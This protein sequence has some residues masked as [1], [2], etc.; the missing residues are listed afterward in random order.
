[1]GEKPVG[2]LILKTA[3]YIFWLISAFP[4]LLWDGMF[5]LLRS[6]ILISVSVWVCGLAS[7]QPLELLV[8]KAIGTSE[9]P[10][11]VGESLRRV[12]ECVASGIL[13]EGEILFE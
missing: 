13:L 3:Q 9:R 11:G 12:L 4:N 8:E 10:M 7:T 2:S 6:S 1:M 5:F